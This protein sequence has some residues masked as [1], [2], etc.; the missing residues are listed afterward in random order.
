MGVYKRLELSSPQEKQNFQ[1]DNVKIV[2]RS[3]HT[4][5]IVFL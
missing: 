4:N 5:P 3:Y 1:P 2:Y